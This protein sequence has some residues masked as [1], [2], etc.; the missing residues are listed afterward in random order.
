MAY[1]KIFN[2]SDTRRYHTDMRNSLFMWKKFF[3]KKFDPETKHRILREPDIHGRTALIKPYVR[4][5]SI[6]TRLV[7]S[8]RK[9]I[10][11][12]DLYVK[13]KA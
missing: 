5:K 1:N 11:A 8:M 6:S 3:K 9:T 10:L 12:Y 13:R 2:K 7:L 4:A